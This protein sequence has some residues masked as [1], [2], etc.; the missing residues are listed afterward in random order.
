MASKRDYYEVLGIQRGAGDQEIK[1]AFRKM[2]KKYHP[3]ANPGDKEAEEKFKEVNEAYEVLSDPQKKAA[4]DQYG[5]SAFEQGG[6]GGGGFSGGFGGFS[7]MDMGDIFS[8]IF[9]DGFGDIFGGGRSRSSRSG[10]QRGSDLQMSMTISFEESMFGCKKEVNIPVYETCDDCKGSGAKKGTTAETCPYCHGTGQEKITQQTPFGMISSTR[11]C[12]HCRGEG[13]IIKEKCPKCGGNGNIKVNK[14]VT[15]EIPKGISAGQSIRKRGLG[16]A[17][18]KGGPNGDL[19]IQINVVPSKTFIRQGNDLY[20]NVP[21][22]ITQAVFGGKINVPTIDGDYE[23]EL[24]SGTQPD[25]KATIR[26]KGAY[27]VKNDKYRGNLVVTF[28]VVIPTELNKDQRE[29]LE[30]FAEAS[31]EKQHSKKKGWFK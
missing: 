6:M 5:H 4:Y 25:T 17:G 13:K 10:P 16:G 19:F 24:K 21:I 28:N 23:Y 29:A 20:V 1:K 15:V 9:G 7:G 27:N 18:I 31:G 22:S 3:D 30:K 2:A 12:S 8:G 11:V 14:N 26:G